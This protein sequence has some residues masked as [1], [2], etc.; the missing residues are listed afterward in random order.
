LHAVIGPTYDSSV[1]RW[2][3][4][5]TLDPDREEPLFL[6]LA[7]NI[8]EDIQRGRLKPGE[9][10]P[11]SREL[12][13][14]L[15]LNRNTVVA[16]YNELAAQGLVCTRRGRGTFIAAQT[17]MPLIQS[18][19]LP[20]LPT[21]PLGPP[22]KPPPPSGP[23]RRGMLMMS[24]GIPD[25][26]LLPTRAFARAFGRAIARRG[27]AL[28]SH[29]DPQGDVR[30]RCE[31][32]TMLSRTRG[33]S[34]SADEILITHGIEHGIDLVARTLLAPGDTVAVESLGYP[35]SWHALRKAGARLVPVPVDR[36]GL[37][38]EALA[39]LVARE[40]VRAVLLTPHHQFP[41]TVVMP[42]QRRERLA[43]L[44]LQHQFAIIEDDDDYEFH[45]EGKPLFPIAAG[46]G[47]PNAIYVSALFN[48]LAPGFSTGFV[49][50]PR[51]VI[52]RLVEL[53]AVTDAQGAP[54]VERA[55]AELFEEGELLRHARRM[56]RVYA[57]RRDALVAA[58]RSHLGSAVEFEAPD[59]GMALWARV[60]DAIEID[61]DQANVVLHGPEH[62]A[63]QA[64]QCTEVCLQFAEPKCCVF[65][66]VSG[67][68][69]GARDQPEV[70][71]TVS[72]AHGSAQRRQICHP[73]ARVGLGHR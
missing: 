70:V 71:E 57:A 73:I 15:G 10:L 9:P 1:R 63:V 39:S 65:D 54:A 62:G 44:A 41:T 38:V 47:R 32:G 7:N 18:R 11:G 61:G 68:V 22:G 35:P 45:Y 2:E 59:G 25:V 64:A 8:A 16:G 21:Y 23:P 20:G 36:E 13:G 53:R 5:V 34:V 60:D 58:L 31:L 69:G 49:V 17:A 27:A 40:S 3:F 33:F 72:R 4:T 66:L 56:R 28:L 30:L 37:D 48:L 14:R 19:F 26:R 52:E 55:I 46:R 67:Q 29:L 43:E 50:A 24:R 51:S 42:P 12:A 6:Q